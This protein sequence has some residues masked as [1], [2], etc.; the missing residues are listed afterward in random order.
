MALEGLKKADYIE[1][2]VFGCLF[3][4]DEIMAGRPR[5]TWGDVVSRTLADW[6]E[7]SEVF[8]GIASV[9]GS[10]L[11][12]SQAGSAG[13]RYSVICMQPFGSVIT[14]EG[15]TRVTLPHTVS[16]T[17]D[18]PFAALR[19]ILSGGKTPAGVESFAG[20]AVGYL[21]YE[22]LTYTED[23]EILAENDI[24]LPDC[25]MCLYDQ[26]A[27][28]DHRDKKIYL[29]AH[30]PNAQQSLD[31]LESLVREACPRPA[32]DRNKAAGGMES[33]LTKEEYCEAVRRAKE[34]IAA[35]DIYQVNLSQRFSADTDMDA[36]S[37]YMALRDINPAQH[38][39]FIN[40]G[41]FQVISSSP[42]SFLA[43]DPRT[44][45]VVTRPIKGTRPRSDD[46]S[47]DTRLA[48]ELVG[49]EKDRAENIMIVDLERNDLGRVC[50][51]GSVATTELFGIESHP[52]VH[53]LVSTVAG[54]L[55]EGKDAFDLLAA[56]F[57]GGSITGAPKVR[58]MEII[59]ELEPVTRGVY[60]GC[61][62]FIGSG[63][64]MT[65]SIAIRT[66]V[67]RRGVVN[68]HVGGGIVA[69]SDPEMEYQETLDKGKAF[70]EVLKCR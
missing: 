42:E 56:S 11:L 64:D 34:Y 2:P 21:G 70:F 61:I 60:T 41:G 31:D 19:A 37:I 15:L 62:G 40:A 55:M 43:F 67:L 45:S 33:S 57:P 3:S 32:D 23:V 29:N 17:G 59:E 51:F 27:V 14:D 35:G 25:W 47:E 28:F 63:G 4:V 50:D 30:S 52:T 10:V 48:E 65:L 7:P 16:F 20:G 36:W 12:E 66:A 49:S 6:V 24:R 38:A 68:F 58:A 5:D 39:A 46:V 18:S 22:L 8:A 13:G 1:E 69:D 53:H 54:R 44:R 9:P 26:A